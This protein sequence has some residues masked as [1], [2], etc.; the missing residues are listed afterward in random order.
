MTTSRLPDNRR[1]GAARVVA[2]AE[3][4]TEREWSILTTI[5]LL[6][7]AT[8]GCGWSARGSD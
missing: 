2:L 6:R 7:L 3:T 4:L 5:N 8:V 1:Q